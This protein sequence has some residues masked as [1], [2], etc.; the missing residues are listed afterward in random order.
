MTLNDICN[1]V[2]DSLKDQI[3][4]IDETGKIVY[5]NSAW[6]L[7]GLQNGMS[8]DYEW[9]GVNYLNA[10]KDAYSD[11]SHFT[12]NQD[13]EDANNAYHGIKAVVDGRHSHFTLEYPCHSPDEKRWF[14]MDI[15]NLNKQ[16]GF[17]VVSH[18]LI[19]ARVELEQ[20]LSYK[21]K[22]L[23]LKSETDS[24]TGLY[25]R[26]GIER[27]LLHE[28]RLVRRYAQD[29]AVAILDIDNFKN[30]NDTFGHNVGDEVIEHFGKL[31]SQ[32]I[33]DS[34]IVG[35][36]GGDEFLFIF[37]NTKA[38]GAEKVMECIRRAVSSSAIRAGTSYVDV[39]VSYG[40]SE[41]HSEDIADNHSNIV[42]RAD[43]ALYVAKHEG[44]NRGS[45][46]KDSMSLS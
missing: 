17:F 12:T 42:D 45:I 15:V 10:C 36:W 44:R 23:E 31:V 25:N 11:V 34:D 46:Y 40:V 41:Y 29:A 18:K 6:I 4:V 22:Q 39:T 26:R 43:K 19:T 5:V 3:A 13:M 28:L 14:A 37:P 7:F 1:D 2:L 35:R 30:I 38:F 27:L 20:K 21:I 8:K 16:K 32:H 24:M 33:R 9:K